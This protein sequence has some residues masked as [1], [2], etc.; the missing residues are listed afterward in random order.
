MTGSEELPLLMILWEVA[1][2]NA[3]TTEAAAIEWTALFGVPKFLVTD[4]WR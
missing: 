3:V 2:Y 1:A 4:G